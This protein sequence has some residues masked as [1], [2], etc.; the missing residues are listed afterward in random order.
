[1]AEKRLLRPREGRM[2][3]GVCAALGNYFG[4][5]PTWVRIAW[6]VLTLITQIIPGVVLYILAV[7]IIPE[8][9]EGEEGVLDA[10]YAIKEEKKV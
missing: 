3:A 10:E 2:I 6:A 5:D 8:E 9:E 1:M 4:V 7:I